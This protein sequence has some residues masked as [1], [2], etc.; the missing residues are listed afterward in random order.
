[1]NTNRI[2]EVSDYINLNRQS[3]NLRTEIH[4]DSPFYDMEGFMKGKSSLK[5]IELSLLGD[6]SNKSIL[7][8]QCHFGQDSLSM[9][10][11]GARVTGVDLSDKAIEVAK[12][13]SQQLGLNA[14]FI[15][16]NVYELSDHLNSQF[17]IVFTSYGTIGWLPDLMK[18]GEIISRFLKPDGRLVFAEFHPVVWMFDNDFKEI[19]YSYF[20]TEAIIETE[21]GTYADRQ[22]PIH[23]QSVTWN[24]PLSEVFEG[25]IRNGLSI[26]KFH[27][28]DYSPYNCFQHTE[29][30]EPGKFRIKHLGNKIPMV[31]ALVASRRVVP[32]S[33][34][35]VLSRESG[36]Q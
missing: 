35:N 36:S 29:E 8:L 32:S 6:I 16:C 13:L 12:D 18:W 24:H 27:E 2:N 33:E 26:N 15:C 17:D 14:T 9:A 19:G 4:I 7:H 23:H 25:L 1:M 5:E 3:W 11:L 21:S 28:Y 31:Y 34:F 30:F 22:A 10:R 20:N